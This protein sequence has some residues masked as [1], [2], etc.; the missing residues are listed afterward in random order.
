VST[1]PTVHV[2]PYQSTQPPAGPALAAGFRRIQARKSVF[3]I[4]AVA[5][6]LV[7]AFGPLLLPSSTGIQPEADPSTEWL[8]EEVLGQGLDLQ[9]AAGEPAAMPAIASPF[10]HD[11]PLRR[12]ASPAP[13]PQVDETKAAPA[14]SPLKTESRRSL[15][16]CR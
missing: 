4:C 11:L 8:A 15:A 7:A 12:E 14:D 3:I 9:F 16:N 5:A 6:L 1:L 13:A 2:S 10:H